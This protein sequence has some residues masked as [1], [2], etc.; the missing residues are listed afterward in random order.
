MRALALL[1]LVALLGADTPPTTG[2]VTGRVIAV[3]D[4][5]PV[6]RDDVYVYLEPVPRPRKRR[7]LPGDG[8]KKQ[9]VQKDKQFRPRVVVVPIG[10][11]V[12]FPNAEVTS[13]A[14]NVFSPT[15]P[16]FDLGKYG[17][18]KKGRGHR[19]LDADEFNIFCDVHANMW[20]KVKVVDSPY[21]ANVVGGTFTIGNVAPGTY[22]A[23]AWVRNSPEVRLGDVVVTAGGTVTL[24]RDLHLQVRTRS[25]CHDRKDG[26][27]YEGKYA[28][29]CPEDY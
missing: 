15:D 6:A 20:A 23:V 21:I 19:F 17:P 9:I 1:L 28:D 25:G 14:H 8:V 26:T 13:E 16:I 24:P 29:A 7:A 18:D 22:K 12:W 2:T 11:E 3:K 10:A 27:P 4:G 5:K